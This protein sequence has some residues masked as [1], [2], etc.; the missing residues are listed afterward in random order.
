MTEAESTLGDRNPFWSRN[1]LLV[2]GAIAALLVVA[3]FFSLG[4]GEP[5]VK[6]MDWGYDAS[7]NELMIGLSYCGATYAS[8]VVETDTEV[9]VWIYPITPIRRGGPQPACADGVEIQLEAPPGN[10][11]VTDGRTGDPIRHSD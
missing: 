9:S 8:G 6:P 4:R 5:Y 2:A 3:L 10:R 11:T 1:R 7:R